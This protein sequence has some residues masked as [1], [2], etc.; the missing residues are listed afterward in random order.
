VK[1]FEY[2]YEYFSSRSTPKSGIKQDRYLRRGGFDDSRF[3]FLIGKNLVGP[4]AQL[5]ATS[6]GLQGTNEG[7]KFGT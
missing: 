1:Q 2:D 6:Q 3:D 5:G 7:V 4:K